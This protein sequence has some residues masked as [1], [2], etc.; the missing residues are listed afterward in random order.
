VARY[1]LGLSSEEF[2]DL[3]PKEF[4]A[5][6][7]RHKEHIKRDDYRAGLVAAMVLNAQRGKK[8]AKIWQ[9]GDFFPDLKVAEKP[10]GIN[11]AHM[12]AQMSVFAASCQGWDQRG[13]R[14]R[15]RV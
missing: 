7:E 11:V 4:D 8:D 10:R 1:D 15:K 12:R 6:L 2:D 14:G 13:K 5:L 9:P 3:S